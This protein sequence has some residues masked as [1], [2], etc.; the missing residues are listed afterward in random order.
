MK[1]EEKIWE[2]I[3]ERERIRKIMEDDE[4]VKEVRITEEAFQKMNLYA[5]IASEIAGEDI[6]C[7]GYLL[8][9]LNS[10][11]DLARDV[12]LEPYEI[13]TSTRVTLDEGD[14]IKEMRAA[15]ID[16]NKKIS[17]IWHSHGNM[18]GFH[19]EDDDR[20]LEKMYTTN[21]KNK[22]ELARIETENQTTYKEG[23]LEVR[24]GDFI[25]EI[26]TNEQP[27]IKTEKT[28]QR[29]FMN[30]I[31]TTKELYDSGNMRKGGSYYCESL[32]ENRY[33]G[34]NK[35]ENLEIKLVKEENGIGKKPEEIAA[36][37]GEKITYNGRLLKEHANYEN[38][39]RKYSGL[40]QRLTYKQKIKKAYQEAK[41]RAYVGMLTAA[42]LALRAV[43]KK[44]VEYIRKTRPDLATT[45][46]NANN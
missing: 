36:E 34:K 42:I 24:V 17:G 5:K 18:T 20:W 13:A 26:K 10:Y 32:M 9:Y 16:D 33:G 14:R 27:E 40:E 31:V 4:H 1:L 8:N 29:K 12:Y 19:S 3:K 6:E 41:E 39:F 15:T 43:E 30:S 22:I 21:K 2:E 37:C 25:L 28:I 38:V 45:L 11:D 35:L 7:R 44:S 46:E 23:I